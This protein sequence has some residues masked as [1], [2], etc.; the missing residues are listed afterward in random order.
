LNYIFSLNINIF[1][2]RE[3]EFLA[4][5]VTDACKQLEICHFK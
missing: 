3:R 2:E 1:V 4:L 5:F